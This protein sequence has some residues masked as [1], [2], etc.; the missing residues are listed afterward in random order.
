MGIVSIT[1]VCVNCEA[2]FVGKLYKFGICQDQW[3]FMERKGSCKKID[4]VV[5]CAFKG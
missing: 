4:G 3:G 2:T 5:Q 1:L